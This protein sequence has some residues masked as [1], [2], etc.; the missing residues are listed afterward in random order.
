M[1]YTRA[2][3]SFFSPL[4]PQFTFPVAVPLVQQI[5]ALQVF[6]R[7]LSINP[8]L[9]PSYLNSLFT[10]QL[11]SPSSLTLGSSS[12]AGAFSPFQPP[13]VPRPEVPYETQSFPSSHISSPLITRSL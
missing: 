6:F 5:I 10:A 9:L 11:S 4:T 7:L 3:L 2:D 8:R 12:T 13:S 1:G